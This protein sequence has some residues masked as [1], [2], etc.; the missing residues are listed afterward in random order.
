LRTADEYAVNHNSNAV[1]IGPNV[2]IDFIKQ[3]DGEFKGRHLLEIINQYGD[4]TSF[5]MLL[6]LFD[7]NASSESLSDEGKLWKIIIAK[8]NGR[9]L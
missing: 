7:E 5:A 8:Y 3:Y 9:E 4:S 2:K 6:P 1:F